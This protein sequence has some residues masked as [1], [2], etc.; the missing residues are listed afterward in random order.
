M[1]W[2]KAG[3][4]TRFRILFL[5][6]WFLS[7]VLLA[8][9]APRGPNP[10]PPERVLHRLRWSFL[11]FII[12][13]MLAGAGI[14]TQASFTATKGL[15]ESI[16]FTL[17]L[18]VSRFRL[19]ASR[20]GLGFLETVGVVAAMCFWSMGRATNVDGHTSRCPML[21]NTWWSSF[22]AVRRSIRLAFCWPSISTT[23]G[24]SGR[25]CLRF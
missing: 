15:H 11:V 1:L 17:S 8:S 19:V 10:A 13:V 18:P 3:S 24:R 12:P 20:A 14:K 22:F 23:S 4:E 21:L 5:L 7:I 25:A 9:F 6:V 2:Y 16:H